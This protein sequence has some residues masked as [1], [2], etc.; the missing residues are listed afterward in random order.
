MDNANDQQDKLNT[1]ESEN[2]FIRSNELTLFTTA[3]KLK[4]MFIKHYQ[5]SLNIYLLLP[6]LFVH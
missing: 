3:Y 1:I 4:T 6:Y 2:A 5:S